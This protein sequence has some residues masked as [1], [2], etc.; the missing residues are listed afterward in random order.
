METVTNTVT[1]RKQLTYCAAVAV[2]NANIK[3]PT[4]ASA[5]KNAANGPRTRNRSEKK[6]TPMIR[7]N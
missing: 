2:V 6:D 3:Y 4:A 7:K 5:A 1:I